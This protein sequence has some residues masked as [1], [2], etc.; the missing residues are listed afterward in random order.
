M[1]RGMGVLDAWQNVMVG[2]PK[3]SAPIKPLL[4]SPSF[5][6]LS[7]RTSQIWGFPVSKTLLVGIQVT[8]VTVMVGESYLSLE[9]ILGHIQ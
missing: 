5:Y 3:D 6:Y 8:K 4:S 7:M 1:L 9:F 2:L